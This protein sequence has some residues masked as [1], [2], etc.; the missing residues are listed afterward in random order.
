MFWI[1]IWILI[2]LFFCLLLVCV[3]EFVNGMND[4]SNAVA[5]VIY[6]NSLSPK[7]SVLLAA[8]M[9]F[10]W[11]MFGGIAVA[12][13]IIHLLPLDFIATQS[14]AFGICIVLSLLLAAI[15]WNF[16]V[17]WLGLPSSSSH[18]L[19]GAI[20]GIGIALW[21]LDGSV[22]PNWNKAQEVIKSL[23]ISPLIGFGL[24]FIIMA[25][26]HKIV[27]K[28]DFFKRPG[29]LFN[30]EPKSWIRYLLIGTSAFVSFAHGSNDGQ[31][32]VGLAMLILI[33]LLPSVFAMNPSIDLQAL[34]NDV[35]QVQTIFQ[36]VDES[37]LTP[38]NRAVFWEARD[39]IGQLSTI[40][41]KDEISNLE[42]IEVRK[43]ILTF[44]KNYKTMSEN[45]IALIPKAQADGTLTAAPP[46]ILSIQNAVTNISSATDYAPWW[47]IAMI[48]IS[49]GLG[50]MIGWKRIVVTIG[51]KIGKEK[52][53]Y[54]Q[55]TAGALVTAFTI[56]F[57][58]KLGLPVST[59]HILSSGIAGTM[60]YEHGKWGLQSGT[61]KHI[62]MAWVLTLP[63]TITLSA[64]IFLILYKL[65]V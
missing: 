57:A 28:P 54:A 7:K 50:T 5:P 20:L 14:V 31:K 59:T 51:E 26:F 52:L 33:S 65:F 1:D 3:F 24:A 11:V 35:S 44:Q 17:W 9:N 53:N 13:G 43:H 29:W 21:Y 48:S 41:N 19:I 8:I 58:S 34:K 27:S 64:T 56:S 32:G 10:L 6:T 39:H 45:P 4:T 30:R 42:R 18:A 63:V 47:I 60:S 61:I 25:I 49:L 36:N 15:I 55:A 37:H 23:L 40:L 2:L 22:T 38:E 16:S 12:M 62:L 46:D